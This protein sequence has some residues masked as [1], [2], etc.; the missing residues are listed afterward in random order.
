MAKY[1]KF[2]F[3]NMEFI[4]NVFGNAI[5]L[6]HAALVSVFPIYRFLPFGDFV[7]NFELWKNRV[8]A[9]FDGSA[10]LLL[11]L[12]ALA[13]ALIDWVL[14]LTL[15]RWSAVALC[16][17]GLTIVMSRLVLPQITLAD[18][19]ERARL[20]DLAASLVVASLLGFMGALLLS[21]VL[22]AK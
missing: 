4:G 7:M 14:L 13:M 16:F 15:L 12:G 11:A 22:W 3:L 17:C 18:W 6:F 8:V 5:P 10:W 21:V 2:Y 20:G 9:L 19:L 1:M